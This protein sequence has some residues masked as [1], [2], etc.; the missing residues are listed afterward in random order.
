MKA[1]TSEVDSGSKKQK[2]HFHEKPAH[3]HKWLV[4]IV[5]KHS[6]L[7]KRIERR[8]NSSIVSG[9]GAVAEEGRTFVLTVGGMGAGKGYTWKTLMNGA[10][11]D[12]LGKS[13]DYIV[14]DVDDMRQ[15]SSAFK[16]VLKYAKKHRAR[17]PKNLLTDKRLFKHKKNSTQSWLQLSRKYMKSLRSTIF[18]PRVKKNIVF[19]S[20][21]RD[22]KICQTLLRKA[23]TH[24]KRIV[25]LS[26]RT[27]PAC[28]VYRASV[29]RPALTGRHTAPSSVQS[30]LQGAA[31]NEPKLISLT[32]H[33][34]EK[35]GS[36]WRARE[37]MSIVSMPEGN[38]DKHGCPKKTAM[39]IRGSRVHN[40]SVS[41]RRRL[42]RP[43]TLEAEETAED[44]SDAMKTLPVSE[45]EPEALEWPEMSEDEPEALEWPEMSEDE[46]EELEVPEMSGDKTEALDEPE[47]SDD[48]PEA[49]DVPEMSDDKTEA[50]EE[51]EMSEDKPEALEDLET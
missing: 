34:T 3:Q 1:T 32:R 25:I 47:M 51:P 16:E 42:S 37:W 18:D 5:R 2:Y 19:D 9:D 21:C 11:R 39:K 7:T 40:A 23:A 26:V 50:L 6:P 43:A 35:S 27:T 30:S 8:L 33:L 49:L 36:K 28:A 17:L 22:V 29:L 15:K 13:E 12:L 24:F 44:E 20:S 38:V 45:D 41:T 4:D 10:G 31:K 48:N 14:V 46:P